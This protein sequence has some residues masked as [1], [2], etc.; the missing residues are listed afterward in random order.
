MAV[1]PSSVDLSDRD[2][3]Q[4]DIIPAAKLDHYAVTVIGVGAVGRQVAL[5]L[6]AIG[7]RRM[8][9]IDPETVEVVNLAVQGYFEDDLGVSKVAATG[10]LCRRAN[11]Q[12]MLTCTADRY[13]RHM[14]IGSVIFCCVD[15]IST[16]KL[17]WE[18]AGVRADFFCDSRV[19]AEAIRI[20]TVVEFESGKHYAS[21]FFAEEETYQG[22][23]TAKTTIY[24]SNIAAGLMVSQFTRF[25]RQLPT[26]PDLQFNL[27]SSE[28]TV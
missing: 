11:S 4:R 8:Q 19:A 14:D 22:S 13:R 18:S 17:I 7:V 25:L 16:R 15:S 21:T 10:A 28:F 20:L 1:S 24:C 23:C 5:Q 9:L 26:D 3:R 27:L 6:A 2:L 12:L